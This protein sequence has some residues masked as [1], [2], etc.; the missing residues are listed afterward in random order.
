M[1]RLHTDPIESPLP[2]AIEP[3]RTAYPL[4][5]TALGSWYGAWGMQTVMFQWLV[6]EELGESAGRVGTAQMAL[7]LP[8]LLFLLLGGAAA[9][10]VDRRRALVLLHALAALGYGGL[11]LLIA[12]GALSYALLIGYALF[13]GTLQAFVVPTRD[14]QLSEVA[15]A[16]ISRAVAGLTIVQHSGSGLGALV[17]GIASLVGAPPVLGMQAVIALSGVLP[18]R[19]L[20]PS[21]RLPRLVRTPLRLAELRAGMVEVVR[22]PVLRA[23]MLMNLSV[24]L[25]FVG[26]YLVLLPLLVRELYGGGIEKMGLLVGALPVGTI[27]VNLGIVARGGIERQ[28]RALLWGQGFA[29]LCLGALAFGLPFWGSALATFGWGIGAAFAITTSRTLFQ[30]HASEENRGR[31]LSIHSLAILGAGPIGAVLAGFVAGHIGTLMTLAIESVA[32]TVV[33]VLT[34][35][36]TRVRHLR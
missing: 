36:F 9:D 2:L 4:F 11:G 18:T 10:R 29:G 1:K 27:L 15:G 24:G 31:V 25:T 33:I 5:L 12:S 20:P 28:G 3:P 30:E 7:L 22:S 17:A 14:A 21:V 34:L 35:L 6:V 19:R 23:V 8:A 32:M 16:R 13:M 26:A